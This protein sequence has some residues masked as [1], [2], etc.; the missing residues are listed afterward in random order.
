MRKSLHGK[1]TPHQDAIRKGQFMTAWPVRSDTLSV[2]TARME[3]DYAVFHGDK[4]MIAEAEKR[5][6]EA[7]IRRAQKKRQ[8]KN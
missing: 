8:P 2:R 1:F 5:L 7:L 3:L 4:E 6:Q